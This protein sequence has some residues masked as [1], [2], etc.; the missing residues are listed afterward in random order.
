VQMRADYGFALND[1][2]DETG[3]NTDDGRFHLALQMQF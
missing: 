1:I 3:Q 2:D